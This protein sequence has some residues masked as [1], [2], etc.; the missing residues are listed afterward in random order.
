MKLL[1]IGNSFSQDAQKWLYDVCK[2]VG[3]EIYNVNLYY[4]GCSLYAHWKF[5]EEDRADYDYEIK[6]DGNK[7]R[8][9]FFNTDGNKT[10]SC[11]PTDSTYYEGPITLTR[12]DIP[13]AA[14]SFRMRFA[15]GGEVNMNNIHEHLQVVKTPKASKYFLNFTNL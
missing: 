13:E 14:V 5:Y 10:G 4:G 15:T 6:I 3:K 8:V 7:T 11:L 2:N 9:V 12:A 1:S